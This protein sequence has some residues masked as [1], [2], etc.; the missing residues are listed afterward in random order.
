VSGFTRPD[1]GGVRL[2][3]VDV[4][5]LAPERRARLGLIRSFQDAA[6]FPTMTVLETVQLA[7][8]RNLPTQVL[9]A[10]VGIDRRERQR[11]AR[12]TELLHAVGL[13]DYRTKQVRELSTGTRR[14]VELACLIALSPRVLL[15][16]E[17]SSGIAQRETEALGSLLRRL[18]DDLGITMVVIEHDMPLIFG[19]SDRILVM[20][21][22]SVLAEGS[23]EEVR[24]LPQVADSYLGNRPEAIHRS[25]Q[26]VAPARRLNGRAGARVRPTRDE[27]AVLAS[28]AGIGRQRGAALLTAFG[29]LA[30]IRRASVE[31]LCAMPGIGPKRAT[32]LRRALGRRERA[33]G[34]T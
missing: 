15:L 1:A 5:G 2:D 23:A 4:S 12:A 32:E 9:P 29:S 34:A 17:P 7:V 33:R 20:D 25:G 11:L 22:G 31:E 26:R 19:I 30:A 6:L 8:E 16:D 28:V 13:D 3:G 18:R 21:T 10:L 24:A 27:L 14:I